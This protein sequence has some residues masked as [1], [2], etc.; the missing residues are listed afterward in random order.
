MSRATLAIASLLLTSL[1]TAQTGSFT[2][3]GT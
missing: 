3:Y 1:A 2:R